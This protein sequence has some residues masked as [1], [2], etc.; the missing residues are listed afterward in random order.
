MTALIL[1]LRPAIELTDDQFYQ[2]C[3]NNPELRLERTAQGKLIVMPPTGGG[4]G[5]RNFSLT[6]QLAAWVERTGLG[7]GFDSST[8]FR[9]PNGANRSPD[10]SWI[11]NE[12]WNALTLEEQEK[13]P[14]I[15][16]DFV[17]EL[18]SRTDSLEELEE[19]MQEYMENGVRL[20]WLLDP[21]NEQAKIYR[22]GQIVEVLQSPATLSG[23]E[24]LPGFVL[25]LSRVFR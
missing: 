7:E 10:A 17:V 12:R 3:Q 9:L 16:P 21:Q 19:K 11:A 2:I 25:D 1:N 4:S 20:G 6:G 23:E 13:F 5:K 24:V 18:R 14:P 22:Q 15:A 8:V